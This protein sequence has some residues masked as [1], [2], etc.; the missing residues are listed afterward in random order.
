[1]IATD[2]IKTKF[3]KTPMFERVKAQVLYVS[4]NRNHALRGEKMYTK[5]IAVCLLVIIATMSI[6]CVQPTF[7]VGEG[8]W[9]TAYTVEDTQTGQKLIEVD[10][11]TDDEP[12]IYAPIISGQELTVTFTVDVFTSGS[13]NLKLSTY[14]Q[15]PSGGQYWELIPGDYDLGAGYTPNSATME[16]GW[17]KGTFEMICYGKASTVSRATNITLV[18]LSA[19]GAADVLDAIKAVVL[20]A[21]ADE[22]QNL[23]DQKEDKLQ[24]L[25][26]AGVASGYTNLFG[27]ML[28]QSKALVGKG[29][30]NEAIALLNAI[31][32]SGEPMGSAMEIILYP[33]IA[34][35]GVAAAVFAVMFM[36]ARGKNSYFK[37][38]VEDQIKDLEGLTLRASKIDRTMS[39]SLD[40]VKD[41]LK[42]LVGM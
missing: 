18:Q 41:R 34:V 35:A 23:Y 24:S 8:D 15:K 27:N 3:F 2:N 29:Y 14:M 4:C 21:G 39:S 40:S 10:F 9:I 30:V 5:K 33:L 7:A 32:S 19:A 37:L 26:D 38:V 16:F 1:M 20:T 42:R 22:Y 28:N 36:R 13:G 11:A 12:T 25:I 6:I 31:P 17:V